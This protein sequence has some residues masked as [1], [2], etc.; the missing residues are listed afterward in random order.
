M[1]VDLA[2]WEQ[3]PS[4]L[5]T[6]AYELCSAVFENY[7]SL[8]DGRQLLFL[9]LQIGFR[10]LDP[11]NPQIPTKLTHTEYHQKMV[12]IIFES[13]GEDTIADLLHAWTSHSD[14]HKP[15]PSLSKCV[16][17]L[18]G[19]QPSSQ[20]LRQLIIRSVGLISRQEFG[21]VDAGEF[22]QWLN[23]LHVS[24]KDMDMEGRWVN[25]LTHIFHRPEGVQHLSQPYWELLAELSLSG[26][27]QP[28]RVTWNPDITTDLEHGQEV[29]KLE[30]WMVVVWMLWPPETGITTEEDLEHVSLS[31]FRQQPSS[32]WKLGQRLVE[33][34]SEERPEG[35]PESFRQTWNKARLEWLS[36]LNCK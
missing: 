27:L 12:D 1:L 35:V 24:V 36:G 5:T 9:S 6:M 11:K 29:G 7:S 20:R 4:C 8:V 10:H 17:H 3:R 30:C 34:W 13:G 23:R 33:R 16:G 25:L 14:S 32:V 18:I 2:G 19:L 21:E 15:P 31:L 28:Q 22:C 26:S